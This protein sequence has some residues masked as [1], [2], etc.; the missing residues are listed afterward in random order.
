MQA[1][2]PF[3]RKNYRAACRLHS[4]KIH[5]KQVV[6][7]TTRLNYYIFYLLSSVYITGTLWQRTTMTTPVPI[8]SFTV[9]P[10]FKEAVFELADGSRKRVP[11]VRSPHMRIPAVRRKKDGR[12][13]LAFPTYIPAT[14]I[15]HLLPLSFDT[16]EEWLPLAPEP[17]V[18]T[19]PD[20]V[21]L[22]L[23]G[24][25]LN[26]RRAGTLA[27]GRRA[28]DSAREAPFLLRKDTTRML[29]LV[30][31]DELQLYGTDDVE[32]AIHLLRGW[33]RRQAELLLPPRLWALA[34]QRGLRLQR[35]SIRDQKFRMGS[36]TKANGSIR[37]NWRAVLLPP[38]LLDHLYWHELSHL[39]HPNHGPA[40]WRFLEKCSPHCREQEKALGHCYASL[41]AWTAYEALLYDD[42]PSPSSTI[43][44]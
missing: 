38:A 19:L 1:L 34:T 30:R 33:C 15:P 8:T 29:A 36:C 4:V 3:S 14:D 35:V 12:L 43:T 26:I 2:F 27:E 7:Q 11:I 24:D 39:R 37:L 40:F 32:S 28:V 21:A 23:R 41:P 42:A 20:T 5:K 25:V 22:P 10:H 31:E 18:V 6:L 9:D 44:G 13:A 17:L 16:L